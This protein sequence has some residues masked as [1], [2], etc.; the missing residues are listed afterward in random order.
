MCFCCCQLWSLYDWK[1]K[2]VGSTGI[3]KFRVGLVNKFQAV[4]AVGVCSL[5][6]AS[7]ISH[8]YQ[9]AHLN[10]RSTLLMIYIGETGA[11]WDKGHNLK[12]I[13]FFGWV[14]LVFVALEVSQPVEQPHQL[15]NIWRE[16]E[17]VLPFLHLCWR[18][19]INTSYF[20]VLKMLGLHISKIYV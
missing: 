13:H 10:R 11:Q 2:Y 12:G 18:F 4:L 17:L 3:W 16:T 6:L 1:F 19:D 9:L 7:V 15:K 14:K 5:P 20:S 8:V